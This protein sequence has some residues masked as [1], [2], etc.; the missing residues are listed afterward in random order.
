MRKFLRSKVNRIAL[1][2]GACSLIATPIAIVVS[3]SL[4]SKQIEPDE[5]DK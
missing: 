4:G 3:C 1:A 5:I 2:V